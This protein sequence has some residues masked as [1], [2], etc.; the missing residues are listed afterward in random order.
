MKIVKTTT[1]NNLNNQIKSLKEEKE[2]CQKL[3]I[4]QKEAMSVTSTIIEEIRNDNIRL[5]N[6]VNQL[7]AIA[8]DKAERLNVV[9]AENN[10]M[11]EF[12]NSAKPAFKVKQK[13]DDAWVHAIK[14]YK[15]GSGCGF[16]Y[17]FAISRNI[18]VKESKVIELRKEKAKKK[19]A[20]R[21]K[22]TTKKKITPKK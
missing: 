1:L 16:S 10:Q 3:L 20:N 14:T 9:Q 8:R 6:K 11:A 18:F 7:E 5:A 13:I 17:S 12:L 4:N 15:D 21:A 22:K 2:G 19:T